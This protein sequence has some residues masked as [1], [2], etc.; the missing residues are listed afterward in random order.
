M[1][2][3]LAMIAQ[4]PPAPPPGG[5]GGAAAET[6]NVVPLPTESPAH[7]PRQLLVNPADPIASPFGWHDTNGIAGPEYTYT[8]GNNVYAYDDRDDNDQPPATPFPDAGA[9]LNFDYPFDPNGE[10]LDNLNAAVTNLFYMNNMMHDITYHYGFDEQGGNFQVNN[11]GHGGADGDPVQANAIDGFAASPQSVNNAV[12]YPEPDGFSPRIAMYVWTRGGGQLLKVNEPGPV[13]G[14]YTVTLAA[15]S[16]SPFG[17]NITDVP[18]TGD[19]EFI[20]DGSGNPSWGCQQTTQ[21][22]TGKIAMV[23]RGS[24]NFSL[25]AYYAQQA[26]AIGCV[27]CNINETLT[28]MGAGL[29]AS[30]VNIPVVMLKKSDCDKLR[31][32]AGNGLNISLVQPPTTGPNLVDGDFDN[33]VIAHEYGHGVSK[34]LTGGPS[35]VD[36]LFNAE[37]MGEG[38]SDFFSLVTAAKAGD[39]AEKRRGIGTYVLRQPNN[40]VGIRRYPYS[41]DTSINPITYRTVAESSGQHA[42]GEIWAAVT[43]D[44][45]WAMVE[46]YGFD[47]D[48]KNTNSGNGR[49]IQLVIDGLK[50]QPCS[51]GFIDGRNA[52]MKADSIDYS[53]AD[54][55]LISKV[56][57][58]R[59]MGYLASQGS[60]NS[61]TDGVAN[62][63]PIPTCIKELKIKKSTTTPLIEPGENAEFNITV[64]NHKDEAAANVVVTDELPSGLSFIAASNG[65]TYSN[66][67][68]TWNLGT[69]PSGQVVTLTYSAKSNGDGSLRYFHDVMDADDEWVSQ[70]PAMGPEVFALQSSVVKT[71]T[72]AWKAESAQAVS[73][74][75]LD[76]VQSFTV[77]GAQ[78]VLRFWH[79]YN[80]EAGYDAGVFEIRRVGEQTWLQFPADKIFRNPYPYKVDY[81]TFSVPYLNGFS[82][83]SNGWVQSYFD[84]SD[85][86]GQDVTMR[87]RFGTNATGPS[88]YWY[89]DEMEAMDMLNFD[90][91]ACVTSGG[92]QACAKA[93][94]RGVIVQPGTVGALEPG[95]HQLPMRVQPNPANDFLHISLGHALTGSVQLQL[96]GTDGRTVLRRNMDGLAEGQIITLDVQQVP[97]GVY[98]VRLENGAGSSVKKVLIR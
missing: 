59:G 95:N 88:G 91:T 94:A 44:L 47:P 96:M 24:C 49:A 80:T 28:N 90:G 93:P 81:F 87:F 46:K 82:G 45:Y 9:S 21:N 75:T 6:Y 58:R 74:F 76:Y 23:D 67:L 66:G 8:R 89:V 98:V 34:R 5:L 48:I 73:E 97:A 38:W 13:A 29:F 63:D 78:P 10:P 19:V 32:Y 35:T 57:A 4:P 84:L 68:V 1:P 54:T 22:L 77:T 52:I 50:L 55:C 12:F 33:G 56:F 71:G 86:A 2:T 39:V 41:A 3:A 25:K 27:V 65:G 37:Q 40:G 92:D 43:W 16:I 85:Y 20:N 64:I 15:E 72:A 7:G 79:Q 51:P 42:I 69:M 83:N 30:Q 60:F 18:V 62:F 14:A 70:N 36:C 61:S 17:A 11:Y 31:Q 26:G 53:G